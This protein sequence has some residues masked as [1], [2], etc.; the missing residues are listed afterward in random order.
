[1]R[2]PAVACYSFDSASVSTVPLGWT[3]SAVV[4]VR[5]RPLAMIESAVARAMAET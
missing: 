4:I 2:F 5:R 1:M 3:L